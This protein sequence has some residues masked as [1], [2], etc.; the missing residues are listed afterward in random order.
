FLD[1]WDVTHVIGQD[2]RLSPI[3]FVKEGGTFMTWARNHLSGVEEQALVRGNTLLRPLVLDDGHTIYAYRRYINSWGRGFPDI[4][5][6][7]DQISSGHLGELIRKGGVM[8]VYTHFGSNE[9]MPVDSTGTTPLNELIPRR[10]EDALAGLA[11]RRDSGDLMVTTTVRL[12]T[13]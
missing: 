4:T 11:R 12:L 6:L 1:Q 9:R 10:T 13:Y 8:V 7:A 2:A 5:G 3:D